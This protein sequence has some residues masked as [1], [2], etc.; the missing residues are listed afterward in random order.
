MLIPL[1]YYILFK[2]VPIW[3]GQIAFRDYM[4]LDGVL[5]SKWVGLANFK[6][7]IHSFYFGELIRNTMMNSVEN[8]FTCRCPST[9]PSRCMSVSIPIESVQTLAYL[10]TSSPGSSI[11][12]LSLRSLRDACQRFDQM[13]GGRRSTF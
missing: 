2:Y 4:A 7:F 9:L 10:R 13:A 1:A 8:V 11:R 5:G 6:D 12:L 3:N